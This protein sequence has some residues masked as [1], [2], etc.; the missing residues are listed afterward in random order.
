[1]FEPLDS[2]SEVEAWL[3]SAFEFFVGG[4]SRQRLKE[5]IDWSLALGHYEIFLIYS[6]K[7]LI[8]KSLL[9]HAL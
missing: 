2:P 8:N 4:W 7:S 1:M 9:E 6:I 5:A 3:I